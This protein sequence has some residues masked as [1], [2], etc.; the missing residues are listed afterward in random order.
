MQASELSTAPLVATPTTPTL[1]KEKQDPF[2]TLE[3]Q[4]PVS[5]TAVLPAAEPHTAA[6]TS[7]AQTSAIASTQTTDLPVG[8]RPATVAPRS[9]KGW[10]IGGGLVTLL[11]LLA[12]GVFISR[13]T[14][15]LTPTSATTAA[16]A[17]TVTAPT[18]DEANAMAAAS[19]SPSPTTAGEITTATNNAKPSP[20]VKTDAKTTPAPAAAA[21]PTPEPTKAVTENA[22]PAESYGSL[23]E[24]GNRLASAG[25]FQAALQAYEKAQRANPGNADVYYLIGSAYHRSGD[26]ANALEA[27][28]KCTSGSYSAVA[29]NHVKNLEKKLGK[30]R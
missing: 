17:E 28:R 6:I 16:P 1:G 4:A 15:S 11:A 3:P 10:F 2:D 27:Y 13:R 30:N 20:T 9:H 22:A 12:L 19:A 29:A 14:D 26:L 24:Q 25:Q 21:Y 18:P 5:A 7:S 23:I 8:A